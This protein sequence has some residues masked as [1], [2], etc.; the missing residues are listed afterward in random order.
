M[1]APTGSVKFQDFF[2]ERY[3]YVNSLLSLTQQLLIIQSALY[4]FLDVLYYFS[5]LV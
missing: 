3:L 2:Q 4:S 1:F 5:Q